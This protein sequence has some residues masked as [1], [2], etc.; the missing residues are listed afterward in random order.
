MQKVAIVDDSPF[1][2]AIYRRVLEQLQDVELQTFISPRLALAAVC[3]DEPDLIIVDYRMPEID[4]LEF[5]ERFRK[6]N[7]DPD[8]PIL[9]ATA[10]S[11][12]DVRRRALELGASDFI[13]KPADPFEF[14]VR[15]KILLRLNKCERALRLQGPATAASA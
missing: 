2:L 13:Q 9:V 1:T 8:I 10:D 4:G 11:D 14:L 5:I 3:A 7:A 12:A 15:T 6:A